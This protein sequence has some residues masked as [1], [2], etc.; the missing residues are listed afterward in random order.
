[1]L[2]PSPSSPHEATRRA[3]SHSSTSPTHSFTRT[4]RRLLPSSTR[5][6]ALPSATIGLPMRPLPVHTTHSKKQHHAAKSS[7]ILLASAR[8]G[9]DSCQPSQRASF[10]CQRRRRVCT[11]SPFWVPP[12]RATVNHG[13]QRC[14]RRS[15]RR[16]PSSRRMGGTRAMASSATTPITS[17]ACCKV[18]SRSIF[19]ARPPTVAGCGRRSR[20]VQSLLSSRSLDLGRRRWAQTSSTARRLRA[21]CV[22]R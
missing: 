8:S 14:G 15:G 5:L 21:S 6:G 19:Q 20:Q 7:G 22:R 3:P 13:W 12:T 10:I 4:R 1:M 2:P 17:T 16:C 18:H 11:S 9:C